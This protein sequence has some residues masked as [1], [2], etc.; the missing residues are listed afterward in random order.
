MVRSP[1][2]VFYTDRISHSHPLVCL[3][4]R[5]YFFMAKP[6]PEAGRGEQKLSSEEVEE[7]LPEELKPLVKDQN[8]KETLIRELVFIYILKVM[9]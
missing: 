2:S 6:V 1:Q 9:K 3:R 8:R 4:L 5:Q 7:N